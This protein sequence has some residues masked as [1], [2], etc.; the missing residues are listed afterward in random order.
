MSDY[1]GM[2]RYLLLNA[3]VISL[4]YAAE[5]AGKWEIRA[6]SSNGQNHAAVLEVREDWGN[7]NAVMI[8]EENKIPLKGVAV[9]GDNLTFEVPTEEGIYTV[10]AV[11]KGD[12]LE[13]TFTST[14][15][16]KGT[17][18]GKRQ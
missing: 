13:G 15:G 4:T 18:K 8:V 14:D 16:S 2:F 11:V 6:Q 5:V 17:L 7:W 1:I 3:V 10:K 9:D 12:Q